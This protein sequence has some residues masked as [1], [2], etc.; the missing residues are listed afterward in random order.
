MFDGWIKI[1][2]IKNGEKLPNKIKK[3]LEKGKLLKD[4]W[5]K[6][7]LFLKLLKILVV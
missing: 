6:N 5:G 7:K 2:I 3:S 1:E 4:L